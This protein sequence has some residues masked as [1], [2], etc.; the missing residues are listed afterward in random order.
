MYYAP[1]PRARYVFLSTVEQLPADGE[2]AVQRTALK[3]KLKSGVERSHNKNA[4]ATVVP[5]P[6]GGPTETSEGVWRLPML[7]QAN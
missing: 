3:L 5:V 4:V 7:R 1:P 6:V 2:N